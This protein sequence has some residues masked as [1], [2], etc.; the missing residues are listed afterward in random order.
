MALFYR[1]FCAFED[2]WHSSAGIRNGVHALMIFSIE[3]NRIKM[4]PKSIG[5]GTTVKYF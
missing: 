1:H 4:V 3:E 2:K 5:N